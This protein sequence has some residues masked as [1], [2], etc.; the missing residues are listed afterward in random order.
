M[1]VF[2]RFLLI[3]CFLFFKT[4]SPEK[5]I[6]FKTQAIKI[7]YIDPEF[8]QEEYDQIQLAALEWQLITKGI[9]KFIISIEYSLMDNITDINNVEVLFVKKLD[10]DS[11]VTKYLDG[12]VGRVLGYYDRFSD[13]HS[14]LLLPQRLDNVENLKSI[15]LH[16]FGHALGLK[17]NNYILTLMYPEYLGGAYC[18]TYYD[19]KQFCNKYHC[20]PNNFNYCLESLKDLYPE[21]NNDRFGLFN[22]AN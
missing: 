15:A 20:N 10:E 5:K 17:H 19:L 1:I 3:F 21:K 8:N 6:E 18:I 7:L 4:D 2:Y 9:V 11:E 16:E 13:N 22:F 14:I 12:E